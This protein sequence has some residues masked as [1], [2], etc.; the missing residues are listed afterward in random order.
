[1]EKPDIN[2]SIITRKVTDSLAQIADKLQCWSI[3]RARFSTTTITIST[4]LC[5]RSFEGSRG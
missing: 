3:E 5:P 4:I 1:M 2:L